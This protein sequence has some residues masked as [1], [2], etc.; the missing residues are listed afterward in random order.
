MHLRVKNSDN[1]VS[2]V[3]AEPK[4]L[5][6]NC[7]N[8]ERE[9]HFVLEAIKWLWLDESYD[10][11]GWLSRLAVLH[12]IS[13]HFFFITCRL[14]KAFCCSLEETG[15]GLDKHHICICEILTVTHT[16]THTI[17]F[18]L[19]NIDW[20]FLFYVQKHS[21]LNFFFFRRLNM[22]TGFSTSVGLISPFLK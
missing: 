14:S 12:C 15:S 16:H 18:L 21:R 8:K 6:K 19:P 11:R 1:K 9:L 3:R 17:T 2:D 22:T 10:I 4:R 20:K 5:R 13:L 7:K